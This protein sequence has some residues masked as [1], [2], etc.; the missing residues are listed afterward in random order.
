MKPEAGRYHRIGGHSGW[1]KERHPAARNQ[2]PKT[3]LMLHN[4]LASAGQD[5]RLHSR[6]G[7][8]L[9]QTQCIIGLEVCGGPRLPAPFCG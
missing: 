2:R 8:L 5:A 1:R 4:R 6:Q 7:C 3:P 9:P